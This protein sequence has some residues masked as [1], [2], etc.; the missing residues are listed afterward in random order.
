[1]K[2]Y[3]AVFN[4]LKT[5]GVYGIS[6]VENPAMEGTFIALKKEK[7]PIQFATVDK[8]RRELIGLALEPNK[9]VYRNQY[10]EEFNILFSEET[11][12]ALSH[13]FLKAGYQSNSSIEHDNAIEGVTFVESWTIEN[14]EMDKA[15]HFGLSY[16]K[17]SWMVTLKVDDDDLWEKYVKTGKVKG[18]SIDAMIELKEV[19]LKSDIKMADA[20]KAEPSIVETF[21]A[22][23]KKPV[24]VKMGAV[25][26]ADGTVTLEYEGDVLEAGAA[27]WVVA[28]DES[29][30]ALPAGNYPVEGG[31]VVVVKEDGIIAEVQSSETEKPAESKADPKPAD[32]STGITDDQMAQIKSV[33][34]KYNNEKEKEL[35][36]LKT[37]FAKVEKELVELKKQPAS[38]PI[39]QPVAATGKQSLNEFLNSNL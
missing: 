17:G 21:L 1:M 20:K 4:A 3:E 37:A 18:F 7:Q 16:P 24:E 19:N 29:K 26:S 31:Q 33:L 15:K 36:T 9:P 8:E 11:I 34:V 30:V 39:K 23:F 25:K 35:I 6:L 27:V 2:T 28:E 14:P 38:K 22:K 5:H 12:K 10:G 32:M 13:N